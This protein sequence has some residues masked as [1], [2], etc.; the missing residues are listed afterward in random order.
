MSPFARAKP[1]VRPNIPVN[2]FSRTVGDNLLTEIGNGVSR[3]LRMRMEA[4][5]H[6]MHISRII[7]V[8]AFYLH[9]IDPSS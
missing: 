8:Y 2:I 5:E 1:K 9:H 3:K 4:H 6:T 7:H